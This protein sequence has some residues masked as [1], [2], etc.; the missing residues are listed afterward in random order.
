[1]YIKRDY[2]KS[3][4]QSR[5]PKS[6]FLLYLALFGLLIGGV[7]G[8]FFYRTEGKVI[9]NPELALT[10]AFSFIAPEMSPTPQPSYLA[11]QA[12][13]MYWA[14][15]LEDAA[16]LMAQALAMRPDSIDYL[17]EYGMLLIDLDDGR[18]EYDQQAEELGRQIIALNPSDPR[19]YALRA[20]A[21]VWQGQAS[22]AI[23]VA[24][25]GVDID[26][27]FAPLYEALSW[28]Y[29]GDGNLRAGQEAGLQAIELSA[30]D[31]RAHWAYASSLANSGATDEAIIEYE[32]TV[33]VHPNFLPPY[34]ELAFLYLASNRDQEAIDTYDRILGVQPRNPRALLR[35][36]EA[37]RK[38]GQFERAMGLCQDAV[39]SDPNYTS[40]LYR[41]GLLLY[42]EFDFVAA[43]QHFQTCVTLDNSNL[44]CKY[45]LGLTNY[46]IAKD[47]YR[48]NCEA[49]R[50]SPL[51]CPSIEVCRSGWN[52]LQ[53]S[54][55][56][57]QARENTE[58]DIE[59]IREG[60]GAISGD[61]A[62][63]GVSGSVFPTST[64]SPSPT[65]PQV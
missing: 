33:Q 56:L 57:A 36:C 4:L 46:Y 25:A 44:E 62:C 26:P 50:T 32:R 52:L 5:A 55:V 22:N 61:I 3:Y 2:S 38:I 8:F 60:L 17:Y 15:Q 1:M 20:R 6:N 31:V 39:Q 11:S 28:A 19:G 48:L 13:D 58:G 43:Q 21:L 47:S 37:Y 41:Y 65:P 34:F 51:A 9:E 27:D 16:E 24:S 18:N 42:N 7:I 14:G 54:L 23:P 49:S 45:R 59:I 29:M 40:A 53:E 63:M 12:Q 30:G 35:Q 10:V 64:P